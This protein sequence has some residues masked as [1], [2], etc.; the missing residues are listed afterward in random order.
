[1]AEENMCAICQD[2]MSNGEPTFTHGTVGSNGH[3]VHSACM[4]QWANNNPNNVQCPI[5]TVNVGNIEQVAATIREQNIF[6]HDGM[7]EQ[8]MFP[9][10]LPLR[11]RLPVQRRPGVLPRAL[12]HAREALYSATWQEDANSEEMEIR[13]PVVSRGFMDREMTPGKLVV[14]IVVLGTSV[15]YGLQ[16][17]SHVPPIVVVGFTICLSASL[18]SSRRGGTR[19]SKRKS[20]KKIKYGG[21]ICIKGKIDFGL[22]NPLDDF[23]KKV[24]DKIGKQTF[25]YITFDNINLETSK[26]L[27][28][29]LNVNTPI[30]IYKK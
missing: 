6:R 12:P 11:A 15:F 18:N 25:C 16:L 9:H 30:H 26:I 19:R 10:G 27:L 22:P 1:M 4:I 8:Y 3:R 23:M 24:N 28:K 21:E 20:L 14:G 13:R 29:I 2:R 17:L 5:C 7:S